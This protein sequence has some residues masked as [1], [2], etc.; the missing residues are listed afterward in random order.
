MRRHLDL[1]TELVESDHGQFPA[2]AFEPPAAQRMD[3]HRGGVARQQIHVDRSGQAHADELGITFDQRLLPDLKLGQPRSLAYEIETKIEVT[4]SRAARQHVL[5]RGHDVA[6][7]KVATT[8]TK[9]GRVE[10]G[11][12][13]NAQRA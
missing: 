8:Q 3:A 1:Q 6:R 4:P 2:H 7:G 10:L 9:R 11:H 13:L 5:H 12:V